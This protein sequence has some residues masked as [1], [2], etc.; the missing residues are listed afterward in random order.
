MFLLKNIYKILLFQQPNIGADASEPLDDMHSDNTLF[1]GD[2][3]G[4]IAATMN[5]SMFQLVFSNWRE[6][7][8][9]LKDTHNFKFTS[10]AGSLMK[11]MV[12]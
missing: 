8:E 7:F 4:P 2:I 1:G 10:A 5:E 9:S 3:C 11:N 6:T 12:I